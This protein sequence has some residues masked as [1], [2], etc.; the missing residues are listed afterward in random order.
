[1][2]ETTR[3]AI[4]ALIMFREMEMEESRYVLDE[5]I[6]LVFY[7]CENAINEGLEKSMA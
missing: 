7:P 6:G 3:E 4:E 5:N 1:M 2:T